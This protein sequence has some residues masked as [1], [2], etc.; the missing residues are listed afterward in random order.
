[1]KAL[2]ATLQLTLNNTFGWSAMRYRYLVKRQQLWEPPLVFLGIGGVVFMLSGVAFFLARGFV[3]AGAQFGQPEIAL[4]GAVMVVSMLV[5]FTGIMG[6]VSVFFFAN[7]LEALVALPLRPGA[8]AAAKFAAVLVGEYVTVAMIL[9]PA[10]LA[11]SRHASGGIGFWVAAVVVALLVP[12]LPLALATLL[13]VLLMRVINRRHRDLFFIASSLL[14]VGAFMY[15]QLSLTAIPPDQLEAYLLQ[16]AAGRL[17]LVAALGGAYPPAVWATRAMAAAFTPRGWA[18]LGGVVASVLAA[19]ALAGYASDR[20]LLGGLIGSR[21]V[22]RRRA[23]PL[24]RVLSARLGTGSALWALYLREWR[25]FIRTPVWALNGLL[26]ALIVPLVL[27]FPALEAGS[28]FGPVFDQ[29][30]TG[31]P[32]TFISTVVVAA[33]VA[34]LAGLN[35]TASTALSREGKQLW[36]SQVIPASPVVQVQ[37]KVLLSLISSG[38]CAIPVLLVYAAVLRAPWPNVVAAA[39]IG[40]AAGMAASLAGLLFDFWRPHLGW[41][42]PQQA[43]K[44][45]LNVLVPLPVLGALGYGLAR[46]LMALQGRGWAP[47]PLLL[48]SFGLLAVLAVGMYGLALRLAPALYS[49]LTVR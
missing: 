36:I 15:V 28:P 22:V 20:L 32:A 38:L 6:I 7:D 45:N 34:F 23:A 14:L 37:G 21:E 41:N 4:T 1:M 16:L 26:G 19:V 29:V 3:L 8:I 9:L 48:L 30:R 24:G 44:Q 31:G 33:M 42:N 27:I 2:W 17:D 25:A 35:T 18:P 43:V 13:S 47:E 39:L 11:Y 12:V 40:L 49:R 46:L 5:F 10:A